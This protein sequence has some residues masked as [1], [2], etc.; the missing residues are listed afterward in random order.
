LTRI[1]DLTGTS[2]PVSVDI[3]VGNGDSVEMHTTTVA[4]AIYD[5][6]H[7][8]WTLARAIPNI[9]AVEFVTDQRVLGIR[10][11]R[12]TGTSS[13][14]TVRVFC[15]ARG[16]GYSPVY[17]PS[18]DVTPAGLNDTRRFFDQC[19]MGPL[20]LEA[21]SF[22]GTYGAW[23]EAQFA[24]PAPVLPAI[25]TGLNGNL[26]DRG[27]SSCLF[28]PWCENNTDQLRLR[29]AFVLNQIVVCGYAQNSGDP[30]LRTWHQG[31]IDKAFLNFRDIL[32]HTCMNRA[33]GYYLNNM[34]N[35][36]K[37]IAPSQN[38][39]RELLQLFS[40][41]V[42]A[43][44]KDG[45][46]Q[47]GSNGRPRLAYTQG[48]VASAARYLS[49]WSQRGPV[50]ADPG[51]NGT[52]ANGD[53]E[54]G[55]AVGGFSL[56]LAYNGWDAPSGGTLGIWPFFGKTNT[57][58]P[59]FGVF[60]VPNNQ[61]IIDRM[62]AII[63][64]IMQQQ[65]TGV[66]ICKQMIQKLVTD[67]PSPQ[68]I[69]RVV[70]AWENNG[71]GVVGDM[72]A[73]LRAILLDAEARGNSK[74]VTFGRAQEW[75]LSYV[76]RQ[77]Y[78]QAL[79]I[80]GQDAQAYIWWS[81]FGSPE[82]SILNKAGQRPGLPIS[83]FNDYPFQY[84]L[85]SAQAPAAA[86]WTAPAMQANIGIAPGFSTSSH[87]ASPTAM[88][89]FDQSGRWQV[90]A[91]IALYDTTYAATAGL[92]AVKAAAAHNALIDKV[93][94]DLHQGDLPTTAERTEILGFMTDLHGQ[95]INTRSKCCWL[96][97]LIL[98]VPRAAVV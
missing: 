97:Q 6:N 16:S 92:D 40:M 76:R 27:I 95:S 79:P 39:A 15:P 21:A 59:C 54:T 80:I 26:D 42:F 77:R 65:T 24:S 11:R 17:S 56:D 75:A 38:F 70:A 71:S 83:V 68:Y 53:M 49:G 29:T 50:V 7:V 37:N 64:V 86:L 81:R 20:P 82:V 5:E 90:T 91:L 69:R 72:K 94:A 93:Y 33:M 88:G 3:R 8:S 18:A 47:I 31:L 51:T 30:N 89:S 58:Y 48:D 22:S 52:P 43:L 60:A 78:A 32:R 55:A 34:K 36:A 23:I 35:S 1:F 45:S 61:Q 96:I 13:T 19:T 67:N 85:S 2:R 46:V 28:K 10:I 25:Q 98:A 84:Q 4:A 74:P 66:Y 41:G 9:S 44:N 73:V 12:T 14:S 63:D 87:L 62:E 57:D